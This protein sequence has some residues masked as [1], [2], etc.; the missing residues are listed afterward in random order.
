M[1]TKCCWNILSRAFWSLLLTAGL[2]PAATVAA[3][4]PAHEIVLRVDTPAYRWDET[5]LH[6]SGYATLDTPGAPALPMWATA[7]ELPADGQ[8]RVSYDP[9]EAIVLGLD[10][11]LP[12]VPVPQIDLDGPQPWQDRADLPAAVALADR[13]DPAIYDG[14]ALYPPQVVEVGPEQWQRGRRLLLLRVFPF[15]FDPAGAVL[16]YYPSVRVSIA[17]DG[18]A[19]PARATRSGSPAATPAAPQEVDGALRI[20]TSQRGL[21][22][23]T[24][25]DLQAAGVSL[26]TLNPATLA[27][28]YLNQ[29][30]QIQVTGAADGRFDPGD[31]VIF[32][33]LPYVGRYMTHNVYQLTYGGNVAG[34]RMAA[35]AVTPQPGDP[36]VTS[37]TRTVRLERNRDYRSLYPLPSGVDRWFDS[38]L[39]VNN[40]VPTA[41]T[42][43]LFEGDSA[44]NPLPGTAAVRVRLH[45]GTDNPADPDQSVAIRLNSHDLGV[46]QWDGSVPYTATA[47]VS[48]SWFDQTP[49]R[50]T[51]E[52]ARAQLP[53]LP[54]YWV[55]PDWVEVA[56]PALLQATSDRLYAEAIP[57]VA[58]QRARVRV[59]GWS[60][61]DV[62]VYDVR[63]PSR[64]VQLTTLETSGSG[65]QTVDFWDEWPA[66]AAGPSYYLAT[67]DAL[68][69]PQAIERDTPSKLL[70]PTNYADYIAIV[71]P[72]LASAVQPLL[73]RRAA[74]GLRVKTVDVQD[75]YDEVNGGRVDPEAIRSFLTYAYLRWNPGGAPPLYVLLVGDGHYD[76]KGHQAPNL[77][78]LIP[79]YLM[80]VDPFLGETAVDNRYASADGHDD[81]L[82]DIAL[83]RI[84]AKT[85]AD[86]TAYVNKV[87]AYESTRAGAWEQ[88]A[89]FVADDKDDPAGNFH[90]LS[91]QVR[92]EWLPEAYE[93][94]PIYYRSDPSLDTGAEMRAAI[95]AAINDGAA[96]VQ[97]FGHASQ[98]RWGSVSMFDILDPMTLA[99]TTQLPFTVHLGCW[100]GYFIGIQGS[101]LYNRNEQSLGEV[102]VLTAG[103]GSVA[104]LSP[105]GLHIGSALLNM[106]RGLIKAIFQDG[107]LRVGD[108]TDAAKLYFFQSG[109]GYSDLIDTQVLLG[110][111]ALRLRVPR[112]G[113][114]FMFLPLLT[115][116]GR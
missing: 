50:V 96:Y 14:A 47:T 88:R 80:H 94:R 116:D 26:A 33:A 18:R 22:R 1:K 113:Y 63:D 32:Y 69:A 35:R 99:A 71:H 52:A 90:T 13:P 15:Q 98:F 107:V 102:L 43:Y 39:F 21:Y 83:G 91:D 86:V 66:S 38:A 42:A 82:P 57:A 37:M 24:Y 89:V 4:P 73:N 100:S 34:A 11:P 67:N 31:L 97:W 29:P 30:V 112:L 62:R 108:A 76:F 110:D 48:T 23:L 27:V 111:P 20:R 70:S 41:S 87:I 40:A 79:P 8:W 105:T 58:G 28:N 95:K 49:N 3:H 46:F 92:L 93:D 55:S 5:G 101:P 103:R 114:Q 64:P 60:S 106:N 65:N 54:L 51:L 85:P 10:K 115:V 17:V 56:Y 75:I 109:S 78:N 9:D 12:A 44:I 2:F 74:E 81:F 7:V 36:L 104:D 45:G 59:Q 19:L 68:L 53:A 16:R 84:P 61:A 25:Q 77:P 72:S 6:V